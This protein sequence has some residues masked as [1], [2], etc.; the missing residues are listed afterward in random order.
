MIE[1][2]TAAT[3]QDFN[4]SAND[5]GDDAVLAAITDPVPL[6]KFPIG[7]T[8]NTKGL[9]LETDVGGTGNGRSNDRTAK[10]NTPCGTSPASPAEPRR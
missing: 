7:F 3:G 10:L 6:A 2:A 5:F 9:H 4:D 8:M 1:Q